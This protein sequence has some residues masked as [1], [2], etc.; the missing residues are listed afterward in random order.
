MENENIIDSGAAYNNNSLTVSPMASGYLN[1][2]GR[3][4]KF[5]AILGF[6]VIGLFV[7][8]GL[9]A[10]S[11]IAQAAGDGTVPGFV[12]TLLY[13]F[14]GALYFFP[15]YYLYKFSSQVRTALVRKDSVEL[16]SAFEN[17]KSHY[18]FLGIVMIIVLSLYA[19]AIVGGVLAGSLM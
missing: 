14:L 3:W 1:E 10:G 12:F 13:L 11:F 17:L 16:D 4:G 18:K 15:V 7:I 19:I 2:T 8:V 6:C 9:F 5:L